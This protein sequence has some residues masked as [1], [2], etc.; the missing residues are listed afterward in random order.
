MICSH[1][2]QILTSISWSSDLVVTV[3]FRLTYVSRVL[4]FP[5]AHKNA[6]NCLQVKL[7]FLHKLSKII[8]E[9]LFLFLLKSIYCGHNLELPWCGGSDK[10][11][12][13]ILQRTKLPQNYTWYS[14]LSG[15]V[16]SLNQISILN[17]TIFLTCLISCDWILPLV[18]NSKQLYFLVF[19][20]LQSCFDLQQPFTNTQI[21]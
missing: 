15:A 1:P 6:N 8:N 7:N 19:N 14:H 4:S 12:Q 10:Y 21:Q 3:F 18:F 5:L 20:T 17:P 11:K 9:Q 13:P 16:W 2:C